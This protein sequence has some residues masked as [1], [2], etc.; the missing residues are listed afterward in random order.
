M[1]ARAEKT[2]A[3]GLWNEIVWLIFGNYQTMLMKGYNENINLAGENN[4]K[5]S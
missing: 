3:D 2:S 4:S 1:Q 5:S